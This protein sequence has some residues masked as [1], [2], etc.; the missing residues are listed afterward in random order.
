MSDK[1]LLPWAERETKLV[2]EF[3]ERYNLHGDAIAYIA[4]IT[5]KSPIT[6]RI[7]GEDEILTK[8]I[9]E[10]RSIIDRR[11]IEKG[12]TFISDERAAKIGVL[13]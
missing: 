9:D 3:Y 8:S 5:G 2:D 1:I 7:R 4:R 11:L 12:Y 6:S 10:A 13:I